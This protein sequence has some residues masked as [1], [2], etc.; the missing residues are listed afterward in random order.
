MKLIFIRHGHTNYNRWGILNDDLSAN[1]RLTRIGKK[2]AESAAEQLKDIDIDH[3]Y[4]SMLPRTLQTAKIINKYHGLEITRDARINDNRTGYNGMPHLVR[5]IAFVFA[6]DRY[7]KHFRNG[8]SL[9][10]SKN[11]VFKFIEDIKN[12]HSDETV[13]VVGHANTGWIIKG[14]V[15]DIPLERMFSGK[16]ING[17]PM[18]YD[19]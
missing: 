3:I 7:R 17:F 1:V 14:Y 12:K 13:L 2:Q 9:E 15:N 5:F 6:K 4:T 8:E 16:I 18:E 10:D 11:R 19:L